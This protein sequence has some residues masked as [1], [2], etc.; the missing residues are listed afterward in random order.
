VKTPCAPTTLETAFRR[1][2]PRLNPRRTPLAGVAL[3]T[4][5]V[6]LW[7]A[8]MAKAFVGQGLFAWSVGVVYIAYDGCLLVFVAWQALALWRDRAKNPPLPAAQPTIGVIIAAYNEASALAAT[9]DALLRQ[10]DPP[11][12]IWL[13]DDGSSDGSDHV[14]AQRYGLARPPL[15]ALSNQGPIAPSLRWLRLEHRGKAYALNAALAHADTDVVVTVDADTLLEP[16]AIFAVRR[17]FA[18]DPGLVVGGGILEPRCSGGRLAFVLQEFQVYEY[19]RNFLGRHAWSR[20][21]SLLLVSGAFAAFRRAAVET[22]GGFDPECWVEDYELIHRLH[23]YAADHGLAWRVRILGGARASTDAPAGFLPFLR[24]RRRWFGGFLQTQ[25][26]NRDM[27]GSPRFGALG[28]VML[29]VKAIDTL[30]PIYGLTATA[31]LFAFFATGRSGVALP[32]AGLTFAKVGLDMANIALL[33]AAYRR[34]TGDR[35]ALSLGR[36]AVCL[37]VEPFSFQILRHLGAAWGWVSLASG[38]RVWGR[39]GW[40]PPLQ[41]RSETSAN[42]RVPEPRTGAPAPQPPNASSTSQSGG[43]EAAARGRRRAR[44]RHELRTRP[45]RDQ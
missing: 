41:A 5:I 25:Y 17:A 19:L 44:L 29:P 39:S 38:A 16:G 37:I 35:T 27:T 14:L 22:V 2:S 30:Q 31:L 33:I 40:R 8:A 3:Y 42:I 6:A 26:W 45:L 7:M 18:E 13:A 32:A 1:W 23:R 12:G 15:N 4:A 28:L 24:Q 21:D 34:W 20:I 36:A 9:I 43:I 11:D 10:S